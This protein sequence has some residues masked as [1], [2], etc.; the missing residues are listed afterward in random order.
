[1]GPNL[2]RESKFTGAKRDREIKYW[3]MSTLKAN[4]S[5]REYFSRLANI[6]FMIRVRF[7]E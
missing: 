4:R 6:L 7:P 3:K 5:T 2:S 1:M